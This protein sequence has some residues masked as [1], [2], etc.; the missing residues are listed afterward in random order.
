MGTK[1]VSFKLPTNYSPELLQGQIAKTLRIKKFSYELETKSLD[2]RNKSNIHWLVKAIVSSPE[3]KGNEQVEKEKLEI[4]YKKSNKKIVVV[5]SGPAGFFNAFV[6]QKAGFDVT[7]IERGSDVTTRGKAISN[8]ERTGTFNAQNNYA[9]GEGGA[10]TFSDGKLTSRSKR[11]SKEKQFILSSY[12]EAGAPEEILY[13]THPHLGTD[14][15]RKIVQNLRE[16]FENFGGKFLFETML[17]DVVIT[18]SKVK[19]VITSKGNFP[20]DALFIAPGHSAFETYKMLIRRGIPFRTKN[21]AIGSRMEH[22]QEIINK[23]QWGRPQ[24]PGVK[25][26]EY[27]LT[28][29]ADGKHSVFSFCMCPGG[30]VV[31]AAAYENTNIVN[32]MSYYKRNGNFANAACVAAIHPDELAGKTVSPVEALD[33]LQK[34]EESFYQYSEGYAAPACSINDFLK[35]NGKGAQF[36]TSYPL[37]LKPAPLW[38]LLPKPVVESMQVGLQDFIRKMRGFENGNLLG[39]ESKTSS[40]VQVIRDKNGLCEGFENIYI[41]GEGSGYAGGIISSAADGIKA[42]IGFLEK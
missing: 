35:Q 25:A 26:A 1:S 19:E 17:E 12:V 23:A 10:G 39:F 4:P 38:D 21:F 13:M 2:A 3:I 31:P 24:L 42:A 22:T 6:L 40:P 30:M 36:E 27:R 11:I 9:F 8:F 37:G 41:I 7:L 33:N 5:G 29:Q 20:A 14:N 18:N 34:L 15:L 32:G 28:S 16:S